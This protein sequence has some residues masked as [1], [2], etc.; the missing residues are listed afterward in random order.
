MPRKGKRSQTAKK[1]REGARAAF[2]K[3]AARITDPE[4][5]DYHVL[6]DD[7]DEAVIYVDSSSDTTS[8]EDVETSVEAVQR[9]YSM[10]DP[11]QSHPK[12]L[13]EGTRSKRRKTTSRQPVYTGSSRTTLWRKN[14]AHKVAA[15]GCVTLDAFVVKKVHTY[16]VNGEYVSHFGQK[17]QH[18]PSPIDSDIEEI[19]PPEVCLEARAAAGRDDRL[20]PLANNPTVP[21]PEEA[22]ARS[23]ADLAE[24][25]RIEHT[26]AVSAQSAANLPAPNQDALTEDADEASGRSAAIDDA[27]SQL[28]NQLAAFCLEKVEQNTTNED[29]DDIDI[30]VE[31]LEEEIR[32]REPL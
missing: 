9:L 26:E 11:P 10:F 13:E 19:A 29:E 30:S 3:H 20:P 27:I 23:M 1:K 24:P 6:D 8:E 31:Q 17:W 4:S 15:K 22:P 2:V 5:P 28:V 21:R 16:S 12:R 25:R 14:A 7:S 18:S 32:V